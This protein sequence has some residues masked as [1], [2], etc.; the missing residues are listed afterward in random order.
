[1]NTKIDSQIADFPPTQCAGEITAPDIPNRPFNWHDVLANFRAH[2][3]QIALATVVALAAAL[4][5]VPIPLLMPLLVD[6]V[7]LEQPA[8]LV[9]LSNQFIPAAWQTPL[10][11]IVAISIF[12]IILRIGSLLL[13]VWH[14]RQFSLISKDLIFRMRKQLIAR[15]GRVSMSEYESLGGTTVASYMVVDLNTIDDF[16]GV[17]VSRFVVSLLMLLGAAGVL[18]WMHWQLG[19]FVLVMNPVAVYFT[20]V[21][22]KKVKKL[23]RREN[24]ALQIFQE[25]LT[26]TLEGIHQIRAANR[27]QHYLSRI[28]DYARDIRTHSTAYTWKSDAASRLSFVVFL[29][30]IDLFRAVAMAMVLLSDLSLGQMIAVF[31]YLWYMLGPIETI[32]SLQYAF[33]GASAAL[34]RVNRLMALQD[35]PAYPASKNPFKNVPTVAIS[36]RDIAFRYGDGPLVLDGVS[37]DIARGEK[38]AVVGASG[39]GKS[40]LVQIL[41]GLYQPDAGEVYFDGVPVRDIGLHCVREHVGTVL[42]NPALFNTSVRENL[43]LGRDIDDHTMWRALEMAKL[44]SLVNS[45]PE[46]F[47]TVIGRDGIRLSGGQR[48]RLAIARMIIA[49][50]KV[51]VLDEATSALDIATEEVVHRALNEFFVGKTTLIIAH[52]LSAVKL[53][54]RV[55]VFDGGKITEQGSHENLIKQGGVYEKLYG[56]DESDAVQ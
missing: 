26:E 13:Q 42:Q 40:T 21:I 22:S 35:E 34:E 56:A 3:A 28:T 2:R 5:S 11:Y 12:T 15:L 19:L 32:L 31:G 4:I 9:A 49:D 17:T 51:V 46:K 27:E 8:Q 45:W 16:T 10:G 33:Q 30:G 20:V 6:E 25:A 23:K 54:D 24:A 44:D 39:G 52:R 55:I 37:L 18:L 14:T 47:D 50:P 36:L 38:V 48:Q 41:L 7:L 53:A 1:M 29:I 43:T